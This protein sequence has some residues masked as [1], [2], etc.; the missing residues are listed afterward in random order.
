MCWEI[1]GVSKIKRRNYTTIPLGGGGREYLCA[2]SGSSVSSL[3]S[4][5]AVPAG[6][7]APCGHH[8]YAGFSISVCFFPW[9]VVASQICLGRAVAGGDGILVVV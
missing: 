8:V 3:Y 1:G 9:C 2:F 6:V 4:T 7:T 5:W